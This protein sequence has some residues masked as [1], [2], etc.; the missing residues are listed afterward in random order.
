M[1][2]IFGWVAGTS[3]LLALVS[4]LAGYGMGTR[5]LA[6]GGVSTL[7]WLIWCLM[8]H[9]EKPKSGSMGG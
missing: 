4:W 7:I 6:V 5:F 8:D 1:R 3:G 9:W 2:E